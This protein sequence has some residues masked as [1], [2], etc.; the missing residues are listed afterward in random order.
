MAVTLANHMLRIL[1]PSIL[2]SAMVLILRDCLVF[3]G[4]TLIAE[5]RF[6]PHIDAIE[7]K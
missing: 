3:D 6:R 4:P 2:A 7:P 5:G 1:C